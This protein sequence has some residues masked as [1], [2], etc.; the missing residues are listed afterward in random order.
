MRL[1]HLSDLHLGKSL[2]D[3]SLIEDQAHALAQ[4]KV[5]ALAAKVD[6]VAITGDVYDRAVPPVEA[7]EL[8]DDL[9]VGLVSRPGVHVIVIPGNHD[10]PERLSFGSRLMGRSRVHIARGGRRLEPLTLTDAHGDVTFYPAPYIS[11]GEFREHAD[12]ERKSFTD[13]YEALFE[14]YP[15]ILPG[16]SVCLAHC[17][18]TGGMATGDTDERSLTVGGSQL[19]DPVVFDRFSLTLL[20]HLHRPQRVNDRIWYAGSLLPY[21]FNDGAGAK[22]FAVYDL[23]ADGSITREE[24]EVQPLRRIGR[25]R[26]TYE[27]VLAGWLGPGPCEDVLEISLLDDQLPSSYV[28]QVK[29]VYR[30]SMVRWLPPAIAIAADGRSVDELRHRSD[31]QVVR[32]FF[33]DVGEDLTEDEFA[34][35]DAVL[36]ALTDA[37]RAE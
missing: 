31:E 36:N 19:T 6:V 21:S 1:L 17:F 15:R 9:L 12:E 28:D 5:V 10:S 23:A 20:G 3:T 27:Q 14:P 2:Y 8:L 30:N 16:R 32:D 18:T 13:I 29:A 37:A 34:M 22:S 7:Q 4:A 24:I 26:G 25:L 33:K 11:P 35:L